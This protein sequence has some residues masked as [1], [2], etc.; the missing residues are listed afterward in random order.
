MLSSV[1]V[2]RSFLLLVGGLGVMVVFS[3][4]LCCSLVRVVL[5][6]RHDRLQVASMR[7]IAGLLDG[8]LSV[9][10]AVVGRDYIAPSLTTIIIRDP[11]E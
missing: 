5:R 11:R 7:W 2:G 10:I 8:C 4:L 9:V 1:S 6:R 3:L